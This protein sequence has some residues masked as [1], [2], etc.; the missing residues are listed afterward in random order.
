ME[1]YGLARGDGIEDAVSIKGKLYSSLPTSLSYRTQLAEACSCKLERK[2]GFAA[3]LEDATFVRGDIV[4]TEKGVYV[5]A[6]GK[7][8]PY[9]E[10]D[11]VPL[12]E[13]RGLPSRMANYLVAIDRLAR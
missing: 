5:F 10:S 4:V 9:L 8:F 11:F 6:G 2:R 1:V 12:S 3:L 7:K 13:A